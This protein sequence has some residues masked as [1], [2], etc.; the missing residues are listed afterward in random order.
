MS[1]GCSNLFTPLLCYHRLYIMVSGGDVSSE[2]LN[3]YAD[4]ISSAA[5]SIPIDDVVVSKFTIIM[6]LID[7][8]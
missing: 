8:Q 2:T 4:L 6:F 3:Y 7:N 5:W 1:V